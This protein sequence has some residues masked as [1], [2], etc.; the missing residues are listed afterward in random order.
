E[1]PPRDPDP[2]RP[3]LG[4]PG[5]QPRHAGG[6]AVADRG[7]DRR[8]RAAGNVYHRLYHE[9]PGPGR[10]HEPDHVQMDEGPGRPDGSRGDGQLHREGKRPVLQPPRVDAARRHALR[11]RQAA[12]VSHGTR[13]RYVRGGH[14]T[15]GDRMERLAHLPDGVLRPALPGLEPQRPADGRRTAI[16]R[17]AVRGQLAPAAAPRLVYPTQGAGHRKPELH[18]GR[19]PGRPGWQGPRVPRRF[20]GDQFQGRTAVRRSRERSHSHPGPLLRPTGRVP[21]RLSR[22]HGRRC[23]RV[24]M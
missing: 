21:Y 11:V 9:R 7:A 1:R 2:N 17:V 5:G 3:A 12:P 6:E 15:P 13:T 8:N 22:P 23:F 10:A 20:G 19:Q 16:R 24:E 14:Q 18:G 4:K